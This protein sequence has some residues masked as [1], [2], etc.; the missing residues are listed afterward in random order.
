[1]P[2]L[3]VILPFYNAQHT[4]KPALQSLQTQIFSDFEVI[5][6]DNASTDSS[7]RIAEAFCE[8]DS[9]FRLLT[10][11]RRGVVFAA[12]T[13]A[14]HAAAP[15]IARMDADD[16][17]LPQRF[18]KQIEFLQQSPGTALVGS[19][20]IYQSHLPKSRGFR[21]YVEWLN[22]VATPEEIKNKRFIE[23]PIANP[24]IMFRRTAMEKH[25]LY[26]KGDFPE[27]YEMILRWLHNSLEMNKLAEPL[28]IWN[29][30]SQRLTRTCPEYSKT[31]FFRIKARYLAQWLEQHNPFHP[32]IWVW[33]AS[34][35]ARRRSE[36]LEEYGVKISGYID[37]IEKAE[38]F[39]AILPHQLPPPRHIFVVSYVAARGAKQEI[40]KIFNQ[41]N[42]VEGLHYIFAA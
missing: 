21:L 1:M 14:H 9:R 12:N 32:E 34:R 33:G 13:A 6:V 8:A 27:D 28:L 26:R 25:G 20:V 36:L 38:E 16:I 42:Y 31:A 22:S 40:K 2:L 5:M 11:T 23:L 39:R 4:L 37:I 19:N 18:M 30:Y 10:E 29:D 7:R 41:K 35:I 3:S 17:A 24:T 15:F